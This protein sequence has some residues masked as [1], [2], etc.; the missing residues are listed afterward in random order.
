[1]RGEAA[2]GRCRAKTGTLPNVSVLSGYCR[3]RG[4][5][6]IAFSF[7]MSRIDVDAA[8]DLQDRMANAIARFRG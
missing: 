6:R 5:D 8:R 4:G 1:M 2:E 3:S 7:L